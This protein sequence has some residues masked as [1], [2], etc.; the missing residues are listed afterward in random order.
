MAGAGY[1]PENHL[2]PSDLIWPRSPEG[3]GVEEL[4]ALLSR[5]FALVGWRHIVER[6]CEGATLAFPASRY[7]HAVAEKRQR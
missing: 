7:F 3:E 2:S 1:G 4:I 5:C 6:A